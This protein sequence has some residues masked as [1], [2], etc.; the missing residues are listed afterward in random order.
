VQIVGA[1]LWCEVLEQIADAPPNAF[2]GALL[3]LPEQDF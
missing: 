2:D 1:F 3:G